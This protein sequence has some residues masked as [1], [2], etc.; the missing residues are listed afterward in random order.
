MPLARF[1]RPPKEF[2][3]L[4]IRSNRAANVSFIPT[5]EAYH[6]YGEHVTL[7]MYLEEEEKIEMLEKA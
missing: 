5:S 1:L 4:T 2:F 6:R 7:E 3:D